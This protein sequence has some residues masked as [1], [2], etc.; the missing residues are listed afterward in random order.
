MALA[1]LYK[2]NSLKPMSDVEGVLIGLMSLGI[3]I[4]LGASLSFSDF[5]ALKTKKKEVLFGL[6]VQYFSMPL[7]AILLANLFSLPSDVAAILLFISCCPGGTTSNIFSYLSSGDL[8]LSILMTS[9]TTAVAFFM[10]PALWIV[11]NAGS[12]SSVNVPIKNLLA[13]LTFLL[14]PVLVGAFV[15]MKSQRVAA[16]LETWSRRVAFVAILIMVVIWKSK[17]VDLY[18]TQPTKT[19]LSVGLLSSFGISVGF[20]LSLLF[21]F[22]KKISSTIG[23]ETG[24]QNAPLAAVVIGLSLSDQFKHLLWV[25]LLYGALSMGS[26]SLFLLVLKSADFKK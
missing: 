3:M 20:F 24:I 7:I 8:S 14:L 17:I 16:H 18:H 13:V 12:E 4:G 22:S 6:A 21:G 19:F 11:W 2:F 5:K 23:F 9:L 26:A 15:R 1:G 25:P 10:T